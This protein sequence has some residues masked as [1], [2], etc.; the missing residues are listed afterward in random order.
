MI[1]KILMNNIIVSECRKWQNSRYSYNNIVYMHKY[2]YIICIC[3][4]KAGVRFDSEF[5]GL[6]LQQRAIF[7]PICVYTFKHHVCALT[8]FIYFSIIFLHN[9]FFAFSI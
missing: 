1:L 7:T 9:F 6:E 2:F 5:I 4:V 3:V 8:Y